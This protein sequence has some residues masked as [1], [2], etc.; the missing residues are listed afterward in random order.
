MVPILCRMGAS[1]SDVRG[2]CTLTFAQLVRYMPLDGVS[3]NIEG[4]LPEL[5]KERS[6]QK[7]FLDQLMDPSQIEDCK[8][9][10][11]INAELRHYQQEGVNWLWFLCKFGLHGILCDDMGLGKTLQTLCIIGTAHERRLDL[12]INEALPSLVVCPSTLIGHWLYETEKFVSERDMQPLMYCGHLSERSALQDKIRC[13][14]YNLVIVSYD[15]LRNDSNFF[16]S[17]CWNY[18]VLD[19]GHIIKNPRTRIAR[20]VHELRAQHRL[21]LSGTPIQN[22]VL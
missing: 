4:L 7:V 15:V 17:L 21:I 9:G 22:N 20:A 13:R 19:E 8:V 5:I 10:I 3:T 14:K 18:V 11:E 6:V 1:G 16:S 2:L 12:K